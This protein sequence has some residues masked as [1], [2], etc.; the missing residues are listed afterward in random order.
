MGLFTWRQAVTSAVRRGG[1]W[2]L[3]GHHVAPSC[4]CGPPRTGI[5]GEGACSGGRPPARVPSSTACVATDLRHHRHQPGAV[6][7]H[8]SDL[9]GRLQRTSADSGSYRNCRVLGHTAPPLAAWCH[10]WLCLLLG[11]QGSLDSSEGSGLSRHVS[12]TGDSRATLPATSRGEQLEKG[13]S[14]AVTF[15]S[16]GPLGSRDGGWGREGYVHGDDIWAW[17]LGGPPRAVVITGVPARGHTPEQHLRV[18]VPCAPPL[19]GK[20]P[21]LYFHRGSIFCV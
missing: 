15:V 21:P 5:A 18:S 16:D 10:Q 17:G 3:S 13:A 1:H 4:S 11:S 9:R 2:T 7:R 12:G 6:L 19:P 20:G 8:V 14:G